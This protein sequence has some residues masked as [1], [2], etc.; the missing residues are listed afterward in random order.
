MSSLAKSNNTDVLAQTRMYVVFMLVGMLVAPSL[1]AVP[2]KSVL[3]FN[4]SEISSFGKNFCAPATDEIDI[5]LHNDVLKKSSDFSAI[6]KPIKKDSTSAAQPE[7]ACAATT[8]DNNP[9]KI[10]F[11][12]Q[13]PQI[14]ASLFLPTSA[15][16]KDGDT[17]KRVVCI[18]DDSNDL[19]AYAAFEYDSE[20]GTAN[21]YKDLTALNG[22]VSF[23]AKLS[24]T[25]G[26]IEI[27]VCYGKTASGNIDEPDCPSTFMTK[28]FTSSEIT[29]DGLDN[30]D[31]YGFKFKLSQDSNVA[32]EWSDSFTA[33]PELAAFVLHNYDGAGNPGLQYSCQQSSG[34]SSLFL[35]LA[36]VILLL[37]RKR[38]RLRQQHVTIGLKI[39]PLLVAANLFHTDSH[40]DP[41]QI[42]IGVTGGMYRPDLDNEKLTTGEYI[43]PF[44]SSMFR[45]KTSDSLGAINPLIGVDF[46]VNIGDGFYIGL[47]TAYTYARGHALKYGADGQ[48]DP[49]N[50]IKNSQLGLHMYQ[51]APQITYMLNHFVDDFP[52]VPFVRANFVAQGYSFTRQGKSETAYN[53]AGKTTKAN[54]VVFGYKLTGGLMFAL[55]FLEPGAL[56]PARGAGLI[57]HVY[58]KA[59]LSYMKLN[60]F[61]RR[62]FNF[63]AKDVMGT[64]LPLMWNFGL[65][66]QLP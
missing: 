38:D 50:P 4:G 58:L 3:K 31:E 10:N 12:K 20:S 61:G 17:G 65:V 46:E 45:R 13:D 41:G 6:F 28:T 66:F 36:L 63:S 44:Y 39:I 16:S 55:D 62:G 35:L 51:V 33:T 59:E 32:S 23:K 53:N 42:N 47:G 26:K 2:S 11:T 57:D 25:K 21:G 43:Y 29:I 40:A 54:G 64:R 24:K 18:Y 56:R 1:M 34:S 60:N 52:L 5:V 48:P 7:S 27:K 15:C 37:W 49:T 8:V 14:K 9:N 19:V 22:Q 30:G